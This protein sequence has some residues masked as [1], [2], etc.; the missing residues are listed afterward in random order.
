MPEETSVLN[1]RPHYM[2]ANA[3]PYRFLAACSMLALL[4]GCG[5]SQPQMTPFAATPQTAS[6][7]ALSPNAACP[8]V[9]KTYSI[10]YGSG[11]MS[12]KLYPVYAKATVNAIYRAAVLFT[13]WPAHKS[14]A[15]LQLYHVSCGT[16]QNINVTL[17]GGLSQREDSCSG[18]TCTITLRGD[19]QYEAHS[20]PKGKLKFDLVGWTLNGKS[21]V[22]AFRVQVAP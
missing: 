13:N 16:N 12:A 9:N 3:L 2:I 8:A 5:G 22:P 14:I 7:A 17:K 20:A 18:G 11:K 4:A 1:E 6:P 19:I 10:A 15:S 21:G